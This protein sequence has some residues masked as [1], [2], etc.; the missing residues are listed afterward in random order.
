MKDWA[1]ILGVGINLINTYVRTYGLDNTIDFIR[2]FMNNP[3]LELKNGQSY[4]DL[5]MNNNTMSV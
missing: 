2:R 3:K 4:Y 5:Y 1:R